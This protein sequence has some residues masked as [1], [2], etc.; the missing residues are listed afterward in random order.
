MEFSTILNEF[1]GVELFSDGTVKGKY[2]KLM[3]NY[4]H[5]NSILSIST[6]VRRMKLTVHFIKL[7]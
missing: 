6:K 2:S 3:Q 1:H 5:F 4:I 7:V